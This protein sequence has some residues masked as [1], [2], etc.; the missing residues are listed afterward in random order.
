MSRFYQSGRRQSAG[1]AFLEAGSRKVTYGDFCTDIGRFSSFLGQT[2]LEEGERVIISTADPYHMSLLFMGLIDNGLVPVIVAPD[3]KATEFSLI[4][5]TTA[6]SACIMDDTTLAD[7]VDD[8]VEFKLSLPIKQI[9][10]K[11][12]LMNKLLPSKK[13]GQSS[14]GN[15]FP[16][17][18][19]GFEVSEPDQNWSNEHEAYIIMTSGSTSSPKAVVIHHEALFSHLDTLRRKF[20]YDGTTRLF[21]ILPLYHA[22]GLIQGPAA[23]CISGATWLRPFP[24]TITNLEPMLL[25][26]YRLQATHLITVPTVLALI[27]RL[28]GNNDDCFDYDE[29]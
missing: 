25:S 20:G 22:D 18:L 9:V 14:A 11:K 27:M 6:A 24:F 3:L 1:K 28:G 19:E 26:L 4:H 29:F 8:Q 13:T 10:R 16:A 17:L 2:G 5:Q 15:H 21:N 23:A 12:S 7:C